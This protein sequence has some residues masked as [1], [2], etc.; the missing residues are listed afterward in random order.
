MAYRTTPARHAARSQRRSSL[1]TA[2][3]DVV[4]EGGFAGASIKRIAERAGVS[5]GTVYTY[6]GSREELLAE[7]FRTAAGAEFTAVSNA[8]AEENNAADRLSRQ[9]QVLVQTFAERAFA[10]RTLAW[11]LLIEPAGEL[12]DA[13]R[14][15]FRRRYA[16]LTEEIITQAVATGQAPDQDPRIVGPGLIGLISEALT[17][18]LTPEHDMPT[19]HLI[20][21]V[22]QMCLRALGGTL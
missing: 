14:L 19:E 6:F 21:S 10:R 8:V 2:G 1:I 13:E 18:P 11:A 7:V 4:A 16:D 9:I 12:V 17:G 20:T 3:I 22:T 15:I 5:A